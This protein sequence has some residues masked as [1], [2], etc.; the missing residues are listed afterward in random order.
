MER[1]IC[2]IG[3]C[4]IGRC[5][6]LRAV[7]V[8][9]P[10]PCCRTEFSSSHRNIKRLTLTLAVICSLCQVGFGGDIGDIS[11]RATNRSRPPA[12]IPF[13][14]Y[15]EYLIVIDGRIGSLEHQ[16]L[17]LDTG[18]NPSMID[19]NVS[20]RLGLHGAS[21]AL[22]L[23][24]KSVASQSVTLPDLQFGPMRRH[25]W[26]VMVADFS[27]IS[28]GLGIRIDA[29]I[30]LDVL[31]GSNFTVDYAKRRIIFGASVEHH[32]V[33]FSAGPQF[34]TVNLKSGGRQ[35]HLLL[36]TGTPQLVLFENRLRGMDY[37]WTGA[38]GSGQNASGKIG[39]AAV[40]LPQAR[41]GGF[42]VGP[43]R[44]SVVTSQQSIENDL[45]GLM[46]LACLR[47]RR[48]SFD[49]DRQLLGWSD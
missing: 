2:S 3:V 11:V 41:I 15:Q 40:V 23:F 9:A 30:G 37:Q 8:S 32:T 5:E 10:R 48:I 49:F 38:I 1:R 13:K 33:P 45:D 34:I 14:A 19:R 46:G 27:A 21:R 47:P 28:H 39:F 35:L 36:D 44:A 22:S 42:E 24:N 29:V 12:E 4:D 43:Q 26:P 18:S 6:S 20:A 25:N 31:G 17:L 16:N 7:P